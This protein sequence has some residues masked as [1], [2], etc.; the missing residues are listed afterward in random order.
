MG[1]TDVYD[2][3]AG[4]ADWIAMGLPTE[5]RDT[6]KRIEQ[7]ARKDA[8]TCSLHDRV[9]HVRAK[10]PEGWNVCVVL[11]T[12]RIVLGLADLSAELDGNQSVEESMRPAPLTFRPGRTVEE[13]CEY[14]Q[15][16]N[17][18]VALVTTSIGQFIGV[19][20]RDEVCGEK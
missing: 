16:K 15:Q 6:R 17:I 7:V 14:L 1:F 2:Y 11:N 20:R 8:P 10:L 3:A 13:T 9:G 19:L 12:D 4:K 18:P 5:H